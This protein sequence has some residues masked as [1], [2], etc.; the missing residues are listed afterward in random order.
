MDQQIQKLK[1]L[2]NKYLH[3]IKIQI[4]KEWSNSLKNPDNEILFFRKYRW[5]VFRNEVSSIFE[6]N[7]AIGLLLHYIYWEQHFA[8]PF[9]LKNQASK[10]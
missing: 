4:G 6:E 10:Y 7:K 1:K 9:I 3:Q 8:I 5:L 2:V